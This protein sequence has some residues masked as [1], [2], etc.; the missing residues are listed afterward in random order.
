MTVQK[1][2]QSLLGGF[3]LG[4]GC[5]HIASLSTRPSRNEID[6]LLDRAYDHGIRVFD[7]A[8]IYGQGDSE[9]R[10][11]RVAHRRGTVICTKAGLVLRTSQSLV[12][13]AKPVLRP[14][15]QRFPRGK[16][17]AAELRQ[18][19]QSVDFDTDLLR[20]RLEGSLR[21]LKREQVEIFLLHCPSLED[22]ADGKLYDLLDRLRE[23]G[24]AQKCGVSANSI[25]EA[26]EITASGRVDT[27]QVPMH[28]GMDWTGLLDAAQ[29]AGVEV[30]AREIFFG[31]RPRAE[32]L[33][34]IMKP[35]ARETRIGTV[36]VG[37]TSPTH[38]DM[39]VAAFNAVRDGFS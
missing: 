23:D 28:P 3:G 29:A 36:L 13:L 9:R 19:A 20:K 8:D 39:N 34:C 37:T 5:S 17:R 10:L 32:T 7:T 14:L 25:E 33:Q 6:H 26:I 38:L 30:M 16:A 22:L 24:L 2:G 12:R 31:A 11:A 15:L 4:L 18:V 21:R 27:L 35:L 1:T